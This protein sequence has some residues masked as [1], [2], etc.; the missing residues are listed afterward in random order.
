[1]ER[2]D[3]IGPSAIILTPTDNDAQGV[4]QDKSESIIVL[5]GGV[6]PEFRIQLKDGFETANLGGGTGILDDS[7]VGR[8]GGN[9]M[10]GSAVTVTEN[11]RLLVEGI[12]YA[13]SYDSTTDQI[14]LKPLAGVWRNDR[15]YDISLNNRDRFV[16][17]AST[18]T[19]LAMAI[20][21]VYEIAWVERSYL[22]TIADIGSRSLKALSFK[23]LSLGVV[24]VELLTAIVS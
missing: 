3:F 9:R 19:L 10:P 24:Q 7:V 23:F 18:G 20:C 17:D 21:S 22:N 6:Y 1:M 15:V 12:D 16:I 11:G 8:S 13:F 14:V 5:N 2:A 4:D